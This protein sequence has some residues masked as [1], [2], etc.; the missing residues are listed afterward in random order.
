MCDTQ[1]YF[2]EIDG[3][4]LRHKDGNFPFR[5]LLNFHAKYS[6]IRAKSLRWSTIPDDA[7]VDSYFDLSEGGF[8]PDIES[9]M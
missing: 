1:L 8:M 9:E 2:R 3:S 4:F 7:V 6:Y 5:R